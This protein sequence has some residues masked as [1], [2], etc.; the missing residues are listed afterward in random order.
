MTRTAQHECRQGRLHAYARRP[1]R[2]HS[3]G[4]F[5]SVRCD[6][7]VRSPG[8]DV[9]GLSFNTCSPGADVGTVLSLRLPGLEMRWGSSCVWQ[10]HV[11]LGDEWYALSML[12][13]C[14]CLPGL[15]DATEQLLHAVEIVCQPLALG[16]CATQCH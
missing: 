11:F 12:R 5:A 4:A 9:A 2:A 14:L 1:Q 3:G 10:G 7:I 15:G 6:A 16:L 8:A 13:I